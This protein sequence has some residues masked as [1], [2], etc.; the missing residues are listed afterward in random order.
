MEQRTLGYRVDH[1]RCD[2]AAIAWLYLLNAL[3]KGMS[4]YL[5]KKAVFKTV[6]FFRNLPCNHDARPQFNRNQV[7]NKFREEH[8]QSW[9]NEIIMRF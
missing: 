9:L 4:K 5:K 3:I 2:F 6:I 8:R 1:C 7:L